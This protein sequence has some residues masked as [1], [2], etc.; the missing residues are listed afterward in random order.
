MTLLKIPTTNKPSPVV[1]RCDRRARP[2]FRNPV[3][4]VRNLFRLSTLNY[5]LSTSSF[6]LL[7]LL[8]AIAIIAI[9][10]GLAFPV[11]QGVQEQAR[12]LQAK[13]DLVQIVNA[14]N[15]YLIEYGRYPLTPS[16]PA[17]VTYG[18][19]TTNDQLFNI[20]RAITVSENPRRIVFLAPP[21]VK[22][23]NQPRSGIGTAA[24]S[25]GQYFDP[26]GKSYLVRL[27][28]DYDNQVRNPYAQGAGSAPY[29]RSS[30]IAWSFG[31]DCLSQSVATTPVDKNTGT[32]K[33][34]IVSWQ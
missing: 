9:L 2:S 29:L 24:P 32:N 34:D 4:A 30:A 10:L 28:A 14:L 21:D 11:F 26:W 25:V 20:L 19:T 7:E 1:I 16:P 27:D 5:Q 8:V 18:V 12:R 6:T 31:K 22:N 33:D 13:N 15:A 17:D 3:S 23:P